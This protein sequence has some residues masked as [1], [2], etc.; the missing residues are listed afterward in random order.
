MP[1]RVCWQLGEGGCRLEERGFLV[2]GK[3]AEEDIAC[4]LERDGA[5][6][7]MQLTRVR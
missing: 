4:V 5:G 7:K 1:A 2:E 3:G 6:S